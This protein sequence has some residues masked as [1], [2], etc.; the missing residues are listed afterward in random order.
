MF[1]DWALPVEVNSDLKVQLHQSNHGKG[2]DIWDYWDIRVAGC[3]NFI[4]TRNLYIMY[5]FVFLAI[6]RTDLTISYVTSLFYFSLPDF[7]FLFITNCTVCCTYNLK[8]N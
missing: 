2:C 6:S 4:D 3:R 7:Y 8:N 5:I 1:T